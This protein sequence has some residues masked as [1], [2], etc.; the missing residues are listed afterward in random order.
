VRELTRYQRWYGR[1]APPPATRTLRAGPLSA[2]LEGID[3]RYVRLGGVEAV[4]RLF[5]AVRDAAWG[6]VPPQ[7]QRMAVEQGDDSFHVSFEA[8]HQSGDLR[9]RWLGVFAADERGE[10]RCSLEGVAETAFSYNRIGFCI[11][12]P[13][14]NAGCRYRARTSERE[15][16]GV[17][18]E[19]IGP[20]RL[21]DG[22]LLPL[23]P[24]FDRLEIELAEGLWA[25][26]S[27]QGDLFEMEDQRNWSDASFKTYSTPLALGWPHRAQAGQTIAQAA[28]LAP[29][30]TVP[31]QP[32]REEAPVAI[33]GEA[34]RLALPEIGLGQASHG[35][36]L[37]EREA[38]LIGLF[39]PDHLR[40]D[41]RLAQAGWER[42][43]ERAA[44]DALATG[45]GLELALFLGDDPEAEL[46]ALAQALATAQARVARVLVFKQGEAVSGGR[47]A[48][49]ARKRLGQAAPGAPFCGGTDQWFVE[50]NRER[51]DVQ[52]L[53]GIAYSLAATVHADDDTSLRETPAAQGDTVRSARAIF[54]LPVVVSPVTIRPRS[55][56]FG[57]A[58][59]PRGLP[60]QVD[61]RQPTLFGAAWTAASVKH[62]AEAQAAAVTYFETTGWRGVLERDDGPPDPGRFFSTAG[63]V[64][65]L[66][67]VL[68]DAAEWR[69]SASLVSIR[70]S[71]PL[72]LEAMAVQS[73]AGL[74]VLVANLTPASLRCRVEGLLAD[75]VRLRTL[76][77]ETMAAA[78]DDPERFRAERRG[79][80]APGG[81][82]ELELL[83]Y[84]VVRID[85][86]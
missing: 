48:R 70:S 72:D 7:V 66:F 81:R 69:R 54:G 23:F 60:F 57:D 58:T 77:E 24:S 9:F 83:P 63:A 45:A 8:L 76:D 49:L 10:L 16:E 35:H 22:T 25:R 3:L 36:P 59:D 50:L 74:H 42:E 40:A 62:M 67:H 51:P 14:E 43:L 26:F 71:H 38:E 52:G 79:Q 31:R 13:R 41:L 61:E 21:E 68:A 27:F 1:D 5:V 30:G 28:T 32:P 12:H 2:V 17:L 64:F 33:V 46:E 20:Q 39:G 11:L 75:C 37:G 6:T 85:P 4:R 15:V 65:P 29:V 18:P 86:A 19:A 34:L 56:P 53:D 82:L 55:W 84:A 73:E 44:A 47:W 78:C 80:N